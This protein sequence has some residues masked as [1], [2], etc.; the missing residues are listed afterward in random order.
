[1]PQSVRITFSESPAQ[2]RRG[3]LRECRCAGSQGDERRVREEAEHAKPR[4]GSGGFRRQGECRP[5]HPCLAR[6][7]GSPPPAAGR[8]LQLRS[9][10][11]PGSGVRAR[12]PRALPAAPLSP[13]PA[14]LLLC[15][16][17]RAPRGR[18]LAL[19]S[20]LRPAPWH[21]PLSR[22]FRMVPC[23]PHHEGPKS[24]P[25][26][27]PPLPASKSASHGTPRPPPIGPLRDRSSRGEGEGWRPPGPRGAGL[28]PG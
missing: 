11:D 14:A 22:G 18:S 20:S 23:T 28:G 24:G 1:M 4:F 27:L 12:A 7:A 26:M 5:S 3:L 21:Q 19:S 8:G 25:P 13:Q 16:R 9:G 6:S 15:P 2:L 17:P 10:P